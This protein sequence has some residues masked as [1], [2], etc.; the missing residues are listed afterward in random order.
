MIQK[1]GITYGLTNS[2]GNNPSINALGTNG[3]VGTIKYR[4]TE[5]GLIITNIFV[6]KNERGNGIGTQLVNLAE[7]TAR[8]NNHNT[9]NL[10]NVEE[11]ATEFWKKQKYNLTD[12]KWIKKV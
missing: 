11:N 2:K 1:N 6:D 9:I 5:K 7:Q 12:N 3:E 10:E 4:I 8:E